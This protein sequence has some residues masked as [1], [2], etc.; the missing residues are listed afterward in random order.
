[1][2]FLL[3]LLQCLELNF[4]Y[5]ISSRAAEITNEVNAPSS[6]NIVS[7]CSA[8]LD[9]WFSGYSE[10]IADFYQ[11]FVSLGTDTISSTRSD[12]L[13]YTFTDNGVYSVT[14]R[15]TYDT[16]VVDT[17]M[18]III[19]ES[20]LRVPNVFTPNGDGKNDEFRVLYR[21]LREFHI[22]VYDRWGKQVYHSDNPAVGWDGRV[23][24]SPCAPGAYFYVIHA[25]GNDAPRDAK[26]GSKIAYNQKLKSTDPE[27]L[28]SLIGVYRLTGDI[29]LLR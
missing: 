8:P 16:C 17:S 7:G 20:M 14:F 21:S 4:S 29:N 13:R 15:A 19:S 28:N 3:I 5:E 9:V 27:V 23:G 18:T 25:L 2:T 22:W 6:S 10:P 1:M 24:G 12:Q 11:Y 26:F